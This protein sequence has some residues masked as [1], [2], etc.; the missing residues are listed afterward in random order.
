MDALGGLIFLL[1]VVGIGLFW[2]TTLIHAIQNEHEYNK[3]AWVIVIVFMNIIG[4][5]IYV[6]Y[7]L[8][9]RR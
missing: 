9:L 3:V 7:R 5:L 6:V 2:V 1:V 4:S 8:F